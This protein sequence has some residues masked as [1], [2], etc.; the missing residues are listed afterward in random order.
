MGHTDSV[1][2]TGVFRSFKLGAAA[3]HKPE[4]SLQIDNMLAGHKGVILFVSPG[5]PY[6]REAQAALTQADIPF[7]TVTADTPQRRELYEKTGSTSVPSVWVNGQ[8]IGGCDDG[9][10]DGMG[11]TTML[12]YTY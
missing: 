3:G 11:V 7:T 2:G 4:P 8:Y 5:C 12:R 6:C 1:V 9:P 10:E